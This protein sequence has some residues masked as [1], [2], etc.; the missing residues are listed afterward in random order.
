MKSDEKQLL[1]LL[2]S[3][4]E[5]YPFVKYLFA[6]LGMHEN[7]AIYICYKWTRKGWYDWGTNPLCGWLT[8]EGKQVKVTHG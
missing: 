5:S 7:R 1:T 3:S 6:K 4:T 2:Q 8:T